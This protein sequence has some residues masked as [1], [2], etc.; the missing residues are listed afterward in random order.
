MICSLTGASL[1]HAEGEWVNGDQNE[2][3][4]VPRRRLRRA[5]VPHLPGV[6]PGQ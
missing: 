2:R 4:V 1:I 5:D 6:L 3:R